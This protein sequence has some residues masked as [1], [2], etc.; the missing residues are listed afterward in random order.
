MNYAIYGFKPENEN[1][2]CLAIV[3]V[4]NSMKQV[5]DRLIDNHC[6]LT[7]ITAYDEQSGEIVFQLEPSVAR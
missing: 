4:G 7:R 3:S 1:E 5:V 2:I 6:V